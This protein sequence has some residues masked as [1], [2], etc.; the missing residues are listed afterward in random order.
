M[1]FVEHFGESFP[2]MFSL[3]EVSTYVG[4]SVMPPFMEVLQ[5][6]YGLKGSYLVLGA[7]AWNCVICGLLLKP[8]QLNGKYRKSFCE[9]LICLLCEVNCLQVESNMGSPSS[10]EG[11]GRLQILS[12]RFLRIFSLAP[13]IEHPRFAIFL[14]IHSF[15]YYTFTAWALFLVPFGI[16]IGISKTVAV[17]LSTAGGIGGFVGKILAVAVF[18]FEK[19]NIISAGIIPSVICCIGLT[20]YI[21]T[22]DYFLLLIFSS[23]CGFSLAFGDSALSA[24]VPEYLCQKHLKQGTSLSYTFGGIFM[25]LGGIV[26]GAILDI[27]FSYVYLFGAT[28]AFNIIIIILCAVL[29]CTRV[30]EPIEERT[31]PV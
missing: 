10:E 16:S 11:A 2:I 7:I 22:T 15:F 9:E 25:M 4:M 3:R 21:L 31:R 23:F 29:W 30:S 8:P 1:S 17:Y 18:H 6:S 14:I 26:S 19:M 20:G 24:V 5:A 28:I 12:R 13:A 27:L